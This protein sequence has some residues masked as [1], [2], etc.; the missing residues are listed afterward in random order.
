MRAQYAFGARSFRCRFAGT[1]QLGFSVLRMPERKRSRGLAYRKRPVFVG[2]FD[3]SHLAGAVQLNT[4]ARTGSKQNVAYGFGTSRN[5]VKAPFSL[6]G[7]H[8]TEGFEKFGNLAFRCHAQHAG[9]YIRVTIMSW[10]ECGVGDVAAAVASG[11]DGETRL[12]V[13]L[14]YAHLRLLTCGGNGGGEA[15]GPTADNNNVIGGEFAYGA[16]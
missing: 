5:R 14:D 2:V 8:Q 15:A 12:D 1:S 3:M 11:K 7:K 9:S 4:R 16:H 10:F 6:L 13:S